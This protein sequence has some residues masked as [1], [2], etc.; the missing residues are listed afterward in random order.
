M[1]ADW[2]RRAVE[3]IGAVRL[4]V[5]TRRSALKDEAM[6]AR[7]T[8]ALMLALA[9]P[10]AAQAAGSA[11][12]TQTEKCKAR[13][14]PQTGKAD[15]VGKQPGSDNDMTKKLSPCNGVLKPPPT[16]DK[17]M[18]RPAPDEGRTPVIKPGEIPAQPPK[19]D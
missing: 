6:K 18:A 9:L 5:M 17:G 12:P 13:P 11:A 7:F 16:G 19:Q 8:G 1:R 14:E 4:S 2:F 3:P 10:A 15:E